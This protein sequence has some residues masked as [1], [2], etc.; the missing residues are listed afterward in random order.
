MGCVFVLLGALVP[1]FLVFLIWL[2]RPAFVNAA[3]DTFIVP[4]LGFIFLPF[5]TLMYLIVFTPGVGIS[6]SDWIWIAIAVVLDVAHLAASATDRRYRPGMN[7]PRQV[8]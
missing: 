6:G 5:T 2:A 3:F 1:R 8:G 7:D 4:L